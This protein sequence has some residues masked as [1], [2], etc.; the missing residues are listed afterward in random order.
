MR[1]T[2][3]RIFR[4]SLPLVRPL[5]L[6]SKVHDTR[7]GLLVELTDDDGRTGLG[8]TSPLPGFSDETLDEAVAQL[9][10]L[11]RRLLGTT[12]PDHL[13]ELSGGFG[14]WLHDMEP[15]PS[16]R[17]G[18]ESAVMNLLAAAQGATMRQVI[19]DGPV[20]SVP[21]NALIGGGEGSTVEGA[22]EAVRLGYRAV[23]LKEVAIRLTLISIRFSR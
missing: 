17:F 22:T 19:C 14:R 7:S 18:F 20:G 2:G 1:I 3:M 10:N 8:E 11:R 15:A 21:V 13:E 23:K 6:R 5:A 9:T 4:F 12:A 16:V